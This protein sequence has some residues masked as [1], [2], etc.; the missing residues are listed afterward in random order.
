MAAARSPGVE[1]ERPGFR[2]LDLAE[3]VDGRVI[4][5]GELEVAGVRSL[6]LA[7]ASELRSR[8]TSI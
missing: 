7:S 1:S 8:A 6:E 5:D 2:L 4:G 3:R